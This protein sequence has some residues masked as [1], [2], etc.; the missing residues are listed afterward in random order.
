MYPYS[1]LVSSL[2]TSLI[3]IECSLYLKENVDGRLELPSSRFEKVL[4]LKFTKVL[5]FFSYIY[6]MKFLFEKERGLKFRIP[7]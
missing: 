3:F 7:F 5:D 2:I 1:N 6:G 4:L